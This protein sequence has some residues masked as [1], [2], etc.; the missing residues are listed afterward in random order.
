MNSLLASGEIPGLFEGEDFKD[1]MSQCREAIAADDRKIKTDSDD[2][3][4]Q[5]F[6]SEVQ[7]NL[8]IV[9]TI[10]PDGEG[11]QNRSRTSPALFNRC[12]IDWFGDWSDDA[13]HQ[14]ASV[15]TCDLKLQSMEDQDVGHRALVSSMVACHNIVRQESTKLARKT[16]HVQRNYVTPRHFI[17]FIGHFKATYEEKSHQLQELWKHL[18]TGLQRLVETEEQVSNLQQ[19]LQ[20]QESDLRTKEILANEKLQKMVKEQ[21]D[22]EEKKQE[23]QAL[24]NELQLRSTEIIQR[25]SIV[26]VDLAQVQ[27]KLEE[28]MNAVKSIK[29][30]HLDELRGMANPPHAI[31]KTMEALVIMLNNDFKMNPP[32]HEIRRIMRADDFIQRILLFNSSRI[33]GKVRRRIHKEYLS[34]SA[35]SVESVT[36]ASLACGPMIR[37]IDSQLVYSAILEKVTPMQQEVVSLER[38]NA[39]LNDRVEQLQITISVLERNI[40]QYEDEYSSLIGETHSIRNEMSRINTKV[41]RSRRL[42]ANLSSETERW[43][44][45]SKE[46][47]KRMETIVGD[48]LL[49]AA[50]MTYIGQFDEYHRE[51]LMK[52][53]ITIIGEERYHIR[54]TQGLSLIEYLS[55]PNERARWHNNNLPQ[56]ELC[57]QNT[58][59]LK[60]FNRYPLI[61]DPAGLATDFL[62]RELRSQNLVQTSFINPSFLKDLENSIRF[63]TPLLIQDAENIDSILNPILN[64]EFR[65]VG[66]RIM[67]RLGAAEIDLSPTFKLYLSTRD[68]TFHFDADVQSRVTSVN[69]TTTPSSLQGQCLHLILK[70]ERPDIDDNRMEQLKLQGEYRMKLRMLEENLL[71]SLRETKGNIL[72]DEVVIEKLEHLKNKATEISAKVKQSDTV[73]QQLALAME[74][75]KPLSVHARRIYF[76]I[77]QLSQ[78]HFLYHFSIQSF[79]QMI[80]SALIEIKRH[81]ISV[82]DPKRRIELLTSMLFHTVYRRVSRSM[83]FEDQLPFALHLALIFVNDTSIDDREI[84][85]WLNAGSGTLSQ[86]SIQSV[87][88]MF[89]EQQLPSLTDSQAQMVARL[90]QIPAFSDGVLLDHVMN[91]TEEWRTFMTAELI[92]KSVPRCWKSENE[93]SDSTQRAQEICESF[94]SLILIKIFREDHLLQAMEH[95][96]ETVFNDKEFLDVPPLDLAYVVRHECD[97]FTPLLLFS[98]P[99]YD[100]SYQI[101]DM[102]TALDKQCTSIAMGTAESYRE[103][104]TAIDIAIKTG[105]WVLLKNIHLAPQYMVHLEKRLHSMKQ[106]SSG[107][108]QDFRLFMSSEI[109]PGLPTNLVCHSNTLMFESPPGIRSSLLQS[110]SEMDAAA[111]NRR[112]IERARLYLLA[113]WLHALVQERMRY[114]PIGWTKRYEFN[115]SD[116]KWALSTIDQWIDIT[117]KGKGNIAPEDIPWKAFRTLIGR[118]IYGGKIDNEYD[119]RVLDSIIDRLFHEDS[120]DTNKFRFFMASRNNTH[121]DLAAPVGITFQ[122]FYEWIQSLALHQQTPEWLGLVYDVQTLTRTKDGLS[123]ICKVQNIQNIEDEETVF[124]EIQDSMTLKQQKEELTGMQIS[125]SETLIANVK[126]WLELLPKGITSQY[127]KSAE[128]SK[129]ALFRCFSREILSAETCLIMVRKELEEVMLNVG[130]N[131]RQAKRYIDTVDSLLRGITPAAWNTFQSI[132]SHDVNLWISDFAKRVEQLERISLIMRQQGSSQFTNEPNSIGAVWMGGLLFPEAFLTATRQFVAHANTWPLE[133]LRL[134]VGFREDGDD[135]SV[136]DNQSFIVKDLVLECATLDSGTRCITSS[137]MLTS[138]LSVAVLRWVKED[139]T[140]N[141]KNNTTCVSCV[142]LPLYLNSRREQLLCSLN[143]PFQRVHGMDSS[144]FYERG[145]ALFIQTL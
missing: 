120:Y 85:F 36:R 99:G 81:H 44:E 134:E 103:S 31:Q 116:L 141:D 64:K 48:V 121:G 73:M 101:D 47:Q 45:Q 15:F 1:L 117:S 74:L 55:K 32:W 49:S 143:I 52:R 87:H 54:H 9:F 127:L 59:I 70:S 68:H 28:A 56:D 132:A 94:R 30:K 76:A 136:A 39:L 88:K 83:L 119:L 58:I 86:S 19:L 25:K 60:R 12:V 105:Q 22:A 118:S 75:Y 140:R 111:V 110:F 126:A 95:F 124:D 113:A 109:H 37:W 24:R 89:I 112:P 145:A 82:T 80:T 91:H 11:F 27:P 96:V 138:R 107:S 142:Q 144:F 97:T 4:Y 50:F 125:W 6:V 108:H 20:K 69:F 104:D 133:K 62:I 21:K 5:W 34:D 131:T 14:V 35:L 102:V 122:H 128:M 13:L 51:R 123:V 84:R 26:E 61:I 38:E 7:R 67:V 29:K 72:D 16:L 93:A 8:H 57:L 135:A 40:A 18:N 42:L 77:E 66:G 78:L 3:L 43:N 23:S 90:I 114:Q 71:Q 10:N 106:D 65:K 98:V 2:E 33:S 130:H 100:A 79:F 41:E 139:D 53:W 46:F 17:D 63:G 115:Q 129:N 137:E 92:D